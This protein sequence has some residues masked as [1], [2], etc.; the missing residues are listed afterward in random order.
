VRSTGRHTSIA[1]WARRHVSVEASVCVIACEVTPAGRT[2]P[3][4]ARAREG[5]RDAGAEQVPRRV[6]EAGG[7]A[8]R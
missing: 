7:V 6:Q 5:G 8:G 1:T 2:P 4:L 3:D